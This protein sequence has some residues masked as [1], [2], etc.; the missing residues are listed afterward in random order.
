[1]NN[2]YYGISIGLLIPFVSLLVYGL[3]Y[4]TIFLLA[5]TGFYA[6]MFIS[7]VRARGWYG[8]SHVFVDKTLTPAGILAPIGFGLLVVGCIFISSIGIS[9]KKD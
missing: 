4:R 3:K 8:G 9:D 2:I 7:V 6:I 5:V 1:M